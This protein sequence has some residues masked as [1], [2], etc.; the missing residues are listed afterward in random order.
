M[1]GYEIANS[2]WFY[3]LMIWTLAWKGYAL[4]KAAKNDSKPWFVALLIINT[5][6]VLEIIYIYLISPKKVAK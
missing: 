1:N 3:P 5:V 4:W 6:G 2:W